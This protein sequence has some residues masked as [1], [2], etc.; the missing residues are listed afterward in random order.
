MF[1]EGTGI[2]DPDARNIAE[3][4]LQTLLSK[5]QMQTAKQLNFITCILAIA[6]ILNVI[7]VAIQVFKNC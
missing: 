2:G 1:A 4:R 5:Q 7:L 3:L 6:T